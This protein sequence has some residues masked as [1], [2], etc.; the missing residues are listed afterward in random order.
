[1]ILIKK[2][3]FKKTKISSNFIVAVKFVS[4][5]E[6]NLM[7]WVKNLSIKFIRPPCRK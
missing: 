4:G 5:A 1:M 2:R 6:M 7:F 3:F